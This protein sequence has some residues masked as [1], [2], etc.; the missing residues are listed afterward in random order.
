MKITTNMSSYGKW[1]GDLAKP[2]RYGENETYQLAAEFLDGHGVIEDW[3]CGRQWFKRYVT[4]SEYVGV[5][6]SKDRQPDVLDDVITRKTD[7][8]CILLRHVLE[9]NY[10]WIKLL[11]N[12][13]NSFN[14]RMTIVF[15]MPLIDT[16]TECAK[17]HNEIPYLRI[18][19]DEFLQ[20]LKDY[21]FEV[22]QVGNETVFNIYAKN[23]DIRLYKK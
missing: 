12:A 17:E 9:H 2:K 1:T 14:K 20:E 19:R 3:G 15:F 10:N 16:P 4:K 21:P 13:L 6:G 23:K 5:D 22:K 8:S 18:N 11:K 7:V